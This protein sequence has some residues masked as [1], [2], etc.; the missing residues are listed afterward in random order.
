MDSTF[1]GATDNIQVTGGSASMRMIVENCFFS[2]SSSA[3]LRLAATAQLRLL[4]ARL[5]TLVGGRGLDIAAGASV[6]SLVLDGASFDGVG[7]ANLTNNS[8]LV[9][10]IAITNCQFLG[11]SPFSVFGGAPGFAAPTVPGAVPAASYR[12]YR[13]NLNEDAGNWLQLE[14]SAIQVAAVP[15]P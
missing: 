3:A 7:A 15:P 8:A 14:E 1:Q 10:G 12:F 11:V 2:G 13:N 4:N 9:G 6:G 5:L